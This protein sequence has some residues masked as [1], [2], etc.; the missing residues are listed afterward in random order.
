MK[1][2][3]LLGIA[4]IA[5]QSSSASSGD[6]PSQISGKIIKR[7]PS[8]SYPA[9]LRIAW[10][11]FIDHK[12]RTAWN[13]IGGQ[14]KVEMITKSS[15]DFSLKMEMTNSELENNITTRQ[16]VLQRWSKNLTLKQMEQLKN[17]KFAMGFIFGVYNESRNN[18]REVFNQKGPN[19]E[20]AHSDM[21]AVFYRSGPID[22]F[23]N[24]AS[25]SKGED[26]SCTWFAQLPQGFSCG[27]GAPKDPACGNFFERYIPT[28]CSKII[29]KVSDKECQKYHK[30]DNGG[31]VYD[32][33]GDP[34]LYPD[35]GNKEDCFTRINW[36]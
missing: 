12:D 22:V 20:Q 4:I 13:R 31:R 25:Q 33:N 21:Y 9:S 7:N 34:V 27:R 32:K 23:I 26:L 1:F 11:N 5:V 36:T 10:I 19:G 30:N 28:D 18:I 3:V 2:V 16:K 17:L 14:S 15:G 35:L 24:A 8:L 6:V 29:V